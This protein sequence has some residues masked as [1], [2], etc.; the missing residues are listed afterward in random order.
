MHRGSPAFY[1]GCLK[2]R[3]TLLQR[4]NLAETLVNTGKIGSYSATNCSAAGLFPLRASS[5]EEKA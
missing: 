2:F 4:K 1:T 3:Q 5:S